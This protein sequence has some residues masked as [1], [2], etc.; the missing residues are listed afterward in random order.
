MKARV[1]H[2][3]LQQ[4]GD[5]AV[6][7][8][9]PPPRLLAVSKTQ[10]ATAVAELAAAGQRE[11][12]ENYVQEARAKQTQLSA[13]AVGAD[14]RIDASTLQWHLIGHLQSNKAKDAA[15][16]FNWVQT[17]DRPTLVH[18]LASY[19]AGDRP[20]LNV[21]IQVNI[22]DEASKHGCAPGEVAA[23]ADAIA[24]QSRLRLRGLMVIPTPHE[25]PEMRRP[26][27]RRTRELFEVLQQAHSSVDTLSM[28]MSD[29]A[30]VAIAEGATMVRI[31]TALFGPRDRDQAPG[32]G[33]R[34]N[35][36]A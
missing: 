36:T 34:G 22:D 27:F 14:P 19:R 6:Q 18:A 3:M 16:L 13:L 1:L 7:A 15:E 26:A 23:L 30:H 8:G 5:A 12:G 31:G 17:V 24:S 20:P 32:A 10:A 21:L 28:G 2:D 25:D 33:D 9:R 35:A 11:F 29:D 4:L